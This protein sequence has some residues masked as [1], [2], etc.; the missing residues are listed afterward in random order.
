MPRMDGY[1]ATQLIRQYITETGAEQP[2]IIAVSGHVEEHYI[3][4]ALNA[5]MNR[6]IAKPA[7]VEDIKD[8][9]RE[10]NFDESPEVVA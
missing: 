1:Q 9:I 8:A 5:G 4:R 10:V 3:Q 7:R 2:T 6:C